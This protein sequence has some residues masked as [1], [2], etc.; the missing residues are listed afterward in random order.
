M[1]SK[2]EIEVPDSLS[3]IKLEQYM[4]WMKV[5][6]ANKDIPDKDKSDFLDKALVEIF[7]KVTQQDIS[8]IKVTEFDKILSVLSEAFSQETKELVRTFSMNGIEYGFMPNLQEMITS[9][10][11]DSESG[12]TGWDNINVAMA[13][14]Y[15]PITAKRVTRGIEQYEIE[16]YHPSDSKIE[17]MLEMPLDAVLSAKVF[18]LRFR[19]GVKS[20]FPSLFG[21]A[22]EQG[23]TSEEN[24]GRKWG[25]YQ[26]I[27]TLAKG[28]ALRFNEATALPLYQA[29]TYLSFEKEK[30]ELEAKRIK[31][32]F[33]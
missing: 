16:E 15:R 31:N 28:D 11:I 8:R 12:L 32:K 3:S 24:F 13:A 2:L 4:E 6:E 25:W 22:E 26:S 21:S 7:C 18:F 9:E 33:K 20:D 17:A 23:Y 27:Y 19:D 5:V 10:Y 29:L 30:N 14:L 1:A